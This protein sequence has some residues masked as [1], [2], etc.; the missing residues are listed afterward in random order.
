MVIRGLKLI[1]ELHPKQRHWGSEGAMRANHP[2]E[3]LKNSG[4]PIPLCVFCSCFAEGSHVLHMHACDH[5]WFF[6]CV[7]CHHVD[8]DAE[9]C[10]STGSST[11]FAPQTSSLI[12]HILSQ[13]TAT[14]TVG[15]VT[16]QSVSCFVLWFFLFLCAISLF[17]KW[18]MLIMRT[19]SSSLVP[20][21]SRFFRQLGWRQSFVLLLSCLTPNPK[22]F[23]GKKKQ[24]KYTCD[25]DGAP[26]L[27]S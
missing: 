1:Q 10:S 23:A 16:Q 12:C 22:T 27:H 21:N 25:P 2:G 7:T 13:I 20:A 6:L 11:P 5:C 8:D 3:I 19:E 24:I 15:L 26:A 17:R 9:I 14:R 18:H 4:C